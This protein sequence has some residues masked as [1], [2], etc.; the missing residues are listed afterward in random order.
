MRE[1]CLFHVADMGAYVRVTEGPFKLVN[2]E[3]EY[4]GTILMREYFE[5]IEDEQ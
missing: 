3:V 1:E 4:D 5:P 2:D